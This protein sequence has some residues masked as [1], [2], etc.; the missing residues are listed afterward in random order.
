ML[1][2]DRT[3]RQVTLVTNRT[4]TRT[5]PTS[6]QIRLI[7]VWGKCTA[8]NELRATSRL[9][10]PIVRQDNSIGKNPQI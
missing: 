5:Y 1:E 2:R 3:F 9:V 10:H 4:H 7:A 6:E 8:K